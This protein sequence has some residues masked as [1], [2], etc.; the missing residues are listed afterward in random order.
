MT[1]RRALLVLPLV[2]AGLA[3]AQS[4]KVWR[5]GFL[6]AASADSPVWGRRVEGF[7]AGLREL[8]YI[9]GKNIVIEFRWAQGS[10]ERLP[11]LA[12]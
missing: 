7:R 1:T 4:R 9:E 11:A 3:S 2:L 12:A 8:G 6:G 5:I 10:A